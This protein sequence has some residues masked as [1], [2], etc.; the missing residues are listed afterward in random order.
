MSAPR[1]AI[2]PAFRLRGLTLGAVALAT[3]VSA[4]ATDPGPGPGPGPDPNT[5]PDPSTGPDPSTDPDGSGVTAVDVVPADLRQKLSAA[6]TL[7]SAGLVASYPPPSPAAL[8]YDPKGAAGMDLLQASSLALNDAELAALGEQ[9]LVIST[10]QQFPSFAYGYKTI[11]GA[12]LPVYVSADSILEAIHRAFDRLLE[13]TEQQILVPELTALL[14][15]MRG[16]L[17]STLTDTETL[18]DADLYLTVAHSLLTGSLQAPSATADPTEVQTL[19]ELARAGSGAARVAL[20]GSERDEDFSQFEPRG[21]YTSTAELA[22]YFKAMMWLGR[23]DFRIVETQPNGSQVFHRRQFDAAAGMYFLLQAEL[24]RFEL[25][26]GTIGAF[27]GEHDSMTPPQ[28]GGLLAALGASTPAEVAALDDDAIVAEMASG[29]WGSQRIASRLI[30]RFPSG[31]ETL[32]LDR[33]FALFGQRYTVDSHT[34]SNVVY[35][36]VPNR[37]LPNP[38]DAAFAALG[39]DA[40]LSLLEPE[41]ESTKYVQAL[42]STRTLVDAHEPAYWEGSLYTRWLGALR[43]LSTLPEGATTPRTSGWDARILSTQLGSWAELRH[44]TL[45]YAKQSYTSGV[46][47]EFPDAY[48]D[49]YPE[50]YARIGELAEDIRSVIAALPGELTIKTVADR[51]AAD[52]KVIAANLQ[53]MA[54]NQLTGAEHSQ[55]LIDFINDAVNWEEGG[56]CG[57]PSFYDFTGWYLRLHLYT[58]LALEY[59]PV[60]A[61]VHTD[62]EHLE[63]LHV[64]VGMPRLMVVT[65]NTCTGPRAYAGLAFAYGEK[66]TSGLERLNDEEWSAKL[67]QEP[68]PDV[69]WMDPVLAE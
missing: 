25:I 13:G 16:G 22:A 67:E 30:E 33:S 17:S 54:E 58:D 14:T 50:F 61:D 62:G 53:A 18:R 57:G 41:F 20:F 43:T 29:G 31:A 35:D 36:R 44:D 49:P 6:T 42:A 56:G 19:F 28:M 37:W 46:T 12:D 8:D 63:V 7:D 10:R 15:S 4:C 23:V 26:D 9:G 48:V 66:V 39:N 65:A 47:C 51:F 5:D 60:V 24:A 45:L 34:F 1:S 59:D 2:P 21:H 55:E 3:L 32:P 68:F 11:Y 38:L 40:A 27:V 52:T 69:P 64:G